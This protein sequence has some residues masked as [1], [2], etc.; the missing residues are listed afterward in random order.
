MVSSKQ[1]RVEIM[2]KGLERE[3]FCEKMWTEIKEKQEKI[4]EYVQIYRKNLRGKI[5]KSG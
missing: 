4:R 2:K 5:N 3:A 1:L